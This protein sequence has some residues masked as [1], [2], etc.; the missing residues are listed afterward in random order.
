MNQ[1]AWNAWCGAWNTVNEVELCGQAEGRRRGGGTPGTVR[2]P[3]RG[4]TGQL[5][6]A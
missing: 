3:L 1:H 5:A 4:R 2:D 6:E